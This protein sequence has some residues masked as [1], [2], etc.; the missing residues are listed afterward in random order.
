MLLR[1]AIAAVAAAGALGGCGTSDAD[2]VRS[3]VQQF[4]TAVAGH[5][6][7]T[8]CGQVLAP[9]LLSRFA[10]VG[11]SCEQAMRSIYLPSVHSPSVAVGRITIQGQKASAIA[12]SGAS[13]QRSSLDTINLV[14]T[15]QGWRIASLTAPAIPGLGAG[16]G[17]GAGKRR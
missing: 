6:Y 10:A 12:L 1:R 8:I 4:S 2:Q 16:A 13:G 14:S 9:S 11:L 5:D 7:R 15:S 3:K 17:A